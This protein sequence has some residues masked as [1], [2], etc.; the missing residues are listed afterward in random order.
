LT[1]AVACAKVGRMPT[2]ALMPTSEVAIALR[3][4]VRTVH[5]MVGDGR[6][7][8]VAKGPGLRGAYLFNPG[9]VDR[10][11]QELAAAGGEAAGVDAFAS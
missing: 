10:L 2:L 11:K 6:L 5:K 3:V 8:P 7:A 1:H 9:D 4:H